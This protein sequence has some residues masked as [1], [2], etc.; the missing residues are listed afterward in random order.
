MFVYLQPCTADASSCCSLLPRRVRG[1]RRAEGRRRGCKQEATS[2]FPF[3]YS[4]FLECS[5]IIFHSV[6]SGL[7]T[8]TSFKHIFTHKLSWLCL[9][10]CFGFFFGFFCGGCHSSIKTFLKKSRSVT[11][12][13]LSCMKDFLCM[14]LH[15]APET[16]TPGLYRSVWRLRLW[17]FKSEA[18]CAEV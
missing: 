14:F 6:F 18:I 10:P 3:H 2:V 1:W 7:E 16:S 9:F 17:G 4:F 15:R 8:V 12:R 5:S 11:G 13:S